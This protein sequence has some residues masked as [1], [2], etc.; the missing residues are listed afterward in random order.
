MKKYTAALIL[1]F[2][3]G[4]PVVSEAIF[5]GPYSGA[6][7]DSQTG[8]PIEGASIL[9]YWTKIIPNVA[10]GNSEMVDVKLIYTDKKG[11]Y[12][13]PMFMA[14]L[15]LIGF[16]ESTQMIIYQPGYQAYIITIWH[17]SR[18]SKPDP[19][20]KNKENIVKLDR[21]PPNFS[22]R[23]HYEDIDHA[24]WGIDNRDHVALEKKELLRRIEW[25]ER[26]GIMEGRK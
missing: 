21:I 12:Q 9:M 18:S 25:E 17:N 4:L 6:V 10:G 13:I 20:F 11:S 3:I 15:G 5:L 14:N 7:M 26:R 2:V 22:H 16:F 24:L 1:F 8:E 23:K 19:N